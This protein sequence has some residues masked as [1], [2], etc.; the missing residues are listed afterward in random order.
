MP[1]PFDQVNPNA[2]AGLLPP[3]MAMN[4]QNTVQQQMAPGFQLQNPQPP[5]GVVHPLNRSAQ[6][7][8]GQAQAAAG[9][10]SIQDLARYIFLQGGRQ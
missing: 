9:A 2:A 4:P 3:N 6:G 5:V 1:S 10:M 7:N 8:S